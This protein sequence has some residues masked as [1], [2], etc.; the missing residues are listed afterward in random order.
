MKFK[1]NLITIALLANASAAM[2]ADGYGI[3]DANTAHLNTKNWKCSACK[4]ETG[5]TGS[6]SVGAGYNNGDDIHSANALAA[7]NKIVGKVDADVTYRGKDGYKAEIKATNLGMENGRAEV[8]SGKIGKYKVTANYRQIATY[9]SETG[10]TPYSG[11][12][13]SYLSLPD[14]WITAGSSDSMTGLQSSLTTFEQSLKRKRYGIGLEYRADQ[15]WSTFVNYQREDKTGVKTTSGTIYNQSTMLPE[16]VDYSTDTVAAGV[17]LNGEHWFTELSYNGSFFRNDNESLGF[18]SAFTTLDGSTSGYKSL[19]PDNDAHTVSL[20]GQYH[21]GGSM[22]SGRLMIGRMSQDSDFVTSGYS[23]ALPESNLDAEVDITDMDIRAVHKISND[24]RISGSYDY[25]DR[26]NQTDVY[27]WTQISVN[28]VTGNAVYNTPYDST[29]QR[30]KLTADYRIISGVKLTGGYD[31]DRTERNYSDREIND[32]NTV[33][34]RLGVSTFEHWNMSVKGSWGKRD[35][36]NYDA[37]QW[38]SSESNALLRKYYLANRYRKM[39]EA[40]V[41]HTPLENLTIDVGGRYALDDYSDTEIGLTQSR[42]MNYDANINYQLLKDLNL[43]LFYSYENIK[44]EQAGSSTYSTP[45]W[46]ANTEDKVDV[47]GAGVYYD[48]LLEKKLRLG[49]DYTYSK[50]SSTTKVRQGVTGDYGDYYSKEHDINAYAQY[51][52][53]EKVALRLDY[54]MIKYLDNDDAND[55]AVDSIWNVLSFGDT[56]HDY[57]AHLVMLSVNYKL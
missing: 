54:K 21:G 37:S 4:I 10:M 20:S 56:S 44:N 39:V 14:S 23:Y 6:V 5:A 22:V 52:A 57:T 19:D 51:Q 2:A 28:N 16:P 15:L 33:W 12:G 41:T 35:G 27:E 34:A 18:D 47:A 26:D 45:N 30:G 53:T 42:D 31:Y 29:K 32:E 3:A 11:I 13:S 48:N 9:G 36:S 1:F 46:F 43:N 38:T 25:Y 40:H 24:L 17:K 7:E 49:L 8:S 55:L 50:S